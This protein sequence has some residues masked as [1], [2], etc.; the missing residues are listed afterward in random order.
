[1]QRRKRGVKM[2]RAEFGRIVG[3]NMRRYRDTYHLTQE[4][5]A[6]KTGISKSHCASIET[7]AKVPS[8]WTIRKIADA[9][10]LSVEYFLY[11][12]SLQTD[13]SPREEQLRRIEST[14]RYCSSGQLHL[15]EDLIFSSRK[16]EI[17]LRDGES[18]VTGK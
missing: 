5:F 12:P 10:E 15:I 4:E 14:L 7:G 13:S 3:D 11:E 2:D 8:A 1:M 18:A 17:T 16:Y 9:L 6:E